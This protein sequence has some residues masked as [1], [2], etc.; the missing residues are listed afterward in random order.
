[1]FVPFVL[2]VS[3]LAGRVNREH[4]LKQY[5]DKRNLTVCQFFSYF[6]SD[7]H[8]ERSILSS[9]HPLLY[10]QRQLLH[11]FVQ[12]FWMDV[13]NYNFGLQAFYSTLSWMEEMTCGLGY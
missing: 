4:I 12:I 10:L 11:V 3:D 7:C 8:S 6:S 5:E 2:L 1:M 13:A 9:H